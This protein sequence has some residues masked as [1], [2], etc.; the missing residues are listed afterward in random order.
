MCIRALESSRLIE[1]PAIAFQQEAIWFLG[2]DRKVD[3]LGVR[4]DQW[5]RNDRC[6]DGGNNDASNE[7]SAGWQR[8]ADVKPHGAGLSVGN[9][10]SRRVIAR[11]NFPMSAVSLS[12]SYVWGH[13]KI[14][15]ASV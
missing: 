10:A 11:C 5:A 15:A 3:G 2:W 7:G 6:I 13:G 8:L 14:K 4:A 9:R 12:I 1:F